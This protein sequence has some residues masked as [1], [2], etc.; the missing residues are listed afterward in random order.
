[1]K[2]ALA[3]ACMIGMI[4]AMGAAAGCD[5]EGDVSNARSC[6]LDRDCPDRNYC[7][8][9]GQCQQDCDPT[10]VQSR[11]GA[12]KSCDARGRC[13]DS[14]VSC[15]T[16][17]DCDG[18]A[19][20]A[21]EC[22]GPTSIIRAAIGRCLDVG[23]GP[24]C[25]YE[26]RRTPCVAGC[27]PES[28]ECNPEVNPCEGKV[29]DMPPG[30]RC[31]GN[32]L[33]TYQA[34]GTCNMN[35]G[36]CSY[37]SQRMDCVAGCANNACRMGTCDGVTCNMPP[38]ARCADNNPNLL[39]SYGAAG[40]CEDN[41]GRPRCIYPS[42]L[43][44]CAYAGGT[45]SSGAC[46]GTKTQI[47]PV[48][49]TEYMAQPAAPLNDFAHEWFEITNTGATAVDLNQWIVRSAGGAGETFTINVGPGVLTL[50]PGAS[51]IL[52]NS[53][54]PLGD[55]VTQAAV[56]YGD[57]L[58]LL[59]EDSIELVDPQ[60][61][62]SDF[63][64][65]E[66][67]AIMAGRSRKLSPAA[68]QTATGNDD[69]AAWCPS[70]T[71]PFG[72]EGKNFGTPGVANTPC[73]ADPCAALGCTGQPA[74]FC[75]GMGDAVVYT[76]PNPT[77]ENTRFNNPFCD[78]KPMTTVCDKTMTSCVAGVCEPFPMNLPMPGQVI[79]T[80]LMGNPGAVPDDDGDWLELYNTTDQ[81]LSLFSMKIEDNETG[82]SYTSFRIDDP[83]L[84]IPARG[85]LVFASS[86]DPAKNGNIMGAVAMTRGLL[87][88]SPAID[89]NTMLSTMKIRLVRPDMIV[90]DEAYY[91]RPVEG[92]SQQLSLPAYDG[93]ANP[94]GANDDAT[95]FCAGRTEY[96]ATD[97]G[98]PGAANIDC[99]VMP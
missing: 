52:G 40:M 39:I 77:C 87:K 12:G 62:T 32:A 48:L 7:G 11:C 25:V 53:A 15:G 74:N 45:C 8:A 21:P 50:M 49:V 61:M 28:G 70:L 27:N 33:V 19:P 31:D 41:M 44:N 71:D 55:G 13:V 9:G 98:T 47:G 97:K 26:D 42:T 78:Y 66:G 56:N 35:N 46:T 76:N 84:K 64:Y 2:S 83:S 81:E 96:N 75:N 14:S 72:P 23:M 57:T 34:M 17:D 3:T 51:I 37:A 94:A 99:A 59:G 95:S 85:Y 68:M 80:E 60:G 89:P 4:A 91:A 29:C 93:A 24:Q 22:D 16:N 54:T 67:G 20:S 18:M 30:T 58:R 1:M 82:G 79:I 65:W 92:A 38:E 88:N 5:G 43:T 73:A 6:A 86:A 69:F 90:V 10:A 63:V 36:M